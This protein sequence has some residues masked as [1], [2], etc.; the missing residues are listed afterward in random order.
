[1]KELQP[2]DHVCLTF[3]DAEERMDL[4]A[5]FVRDGL[6]QG[7]RV[8]CFT[9]SI[10]QA[11]LQ[12]ELSGRGLPID[13]ETDAGR[14][15]LATSAETYLAEG[16]FAAG[17]MLHVVAERIEQARLD[18]YRGLRI[19]ADMCWALRPVAGVEELMAYE[20]Q[21]GSLL[22]EGGGIAVCQYDRR[23]F[24]SVSLAGVAAA[25]DLAV[26]AVTYHD[27]ALLRI[28]RQY[29]P[30]GLRVAGE[31][32]YRAVEPLTRALTESL[33]LDEHLDVNM[34]QLTFID[35]EAAGAVLQA[36]LSLS[37]DQRMTVRSQPLIDKV[38]R[39]LGADEIPQLELV[40]SRDE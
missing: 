29:M 10:T 12:A 14:L 6:R 19:A 15:H 5:A 1:V 33:D 9:D 13:E 39:T 26:A 22:A 37:A 28:C 23:C 3:S 16:S 31:I 38:L 17:R 36:A 27:D 18:G 20:T 7:Q 4:V 34:T 8:L 35:G 30:S 21:L 32:D 11:A 2:G 24:D 25:H 40:I